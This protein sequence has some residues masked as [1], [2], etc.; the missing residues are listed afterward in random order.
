M[1]KLIFK[2]I[3]N[4]KEFDNVKDYNE[5]MTRLITEGATS[6]QA[7]SETKIADE[8]SNENKNDIRL[9]K[10]VEK[11]KEF[12]VNDYCPYFRD[13]DEYYLDYLVSPDKDLNEKNLSLAEKTLTD[14]FGTLHHDLGSKGIS[15]EDAFELINAIK[16]IRSAINNDSND[17]KDAIAQLT[18]SIK[19]DTEKLEMLKYAKPVLGV[20]SDYY[21][22]AFNLVKDYLL[23]Y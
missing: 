4:G 22:S 19:R 9:V 5:A 10:E 14:T 6:I 11:K 2:G 21:D 3:I 8:P 13:N 23:K 17:N 1:R 18:E 20:M 12:D 15:F 16:E 7:S